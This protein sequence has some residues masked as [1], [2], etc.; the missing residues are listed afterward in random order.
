MSVPIVN[1]I[2][3]VSDASLQKISVSRSSFFI[4]VCVFAPLL[5]NSHDSVD[6]VDLGSLKA[7]WY[8]LFEDNEL[9]LL[10]PPKPT[11]LI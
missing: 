3:A 10:T 11:S 8:K 7:I 1:V 4:V 9:V 2:V 6:P 5:S